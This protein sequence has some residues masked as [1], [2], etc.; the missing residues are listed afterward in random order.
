MQNSKFQELLLDTMNKMCDTCFNEENVEKVT[1]D[2]SNLYGKAIV[3]T[4]NR[5]SGSYAIDS[6]KLELNNIKEFIADRIEYIK[7]YTEEYVEKASTSKV[8][9]TKK[10]DD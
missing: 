1:E 3:E 10:E 8:G 9:G 5:F 6:Y 4:W 2:Y 7:F